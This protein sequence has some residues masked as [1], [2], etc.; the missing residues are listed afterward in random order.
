MTFHLQDAVLDKAALQS[1]YICKPSSPTDNSR[2]V[3]ESY[4]K[5]PQTIIGDERSNDILAAYNTTVIWGKGDDNDT[6]SVL[7]GGDKTK[8]V[9]IQLRGLNQNDIFF[10]REK[11][12]SIDSINDLYIVQKDSDEKLKIND[13]FDNKYHTPPTDLIFEDG[14]KMQFSD[15]LSQKDSIPVVDKTALSANLSVYKNNTVVVDPVS[16]DIK[17]TPTNIQE[18]KI[19]TTPPSLNKTPVFAQTCNQYNNFEHIDILTV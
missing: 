8:G 11:D 7:A 3:T 12:K 4:S 16:L 6:V 15:L 17:S 1:R 14:T 10:R 13:F 9:H 18:N 2:L 19:N 5:M